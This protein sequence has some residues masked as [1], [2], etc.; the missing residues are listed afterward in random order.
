MRRV[1][2]GT[3]NSVTGGDEYK[4][5]GPAAVRAEDLVL[6]ARGE[7]HVVE[8][9]RERLPDARVPVLAHALVVEPVHL[10]VGPG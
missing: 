8:E 6:N 9:V 1:C 2:T 5:S 3:W 4:V 7:G 10:C